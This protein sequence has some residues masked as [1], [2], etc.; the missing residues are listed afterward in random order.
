MK[1]KI[2]FVHHSSAIG[3]ASW[4]LYE[5]LK[6]LDRSRFDPVVL[7]SSE[8]PL[9]GRIRSLDIPVE[10]D[11][12]TPVFPIYARGQIRGLAYLLKAILVYPEQFKRFYSHCRQIAPDV[13]YL[14]S[15]AQLFLPWPAK[16][17]GVKR[18]IFHN[19]EHWDPQGIL[20]IKL[21]IRS[22]MIKRFVDE[23]FSITECGARGIGFPEK[24]VVV[25]DWPSFDDETDFDVRKKLGI[26]SDKFLILLTGGLMPIK[27]TRDMLQALETMQ[28]SDQVA[29]I[30]L[31]CSPEG[32]SRLKNT[33]RRLFH[34]ISYA[35]QITRLAAGLSGKVFLLPPTLQVKPYMQQCSVLV[36]PFTMPHAAKA[37]LEAQSLERPVIIYD[38]PEAREYIRNGET[39]VIVP[40]GNIR[41]LASALDDLI[42]HPE[43]TARL[44]IAGREFVRDQFDVV[45]SMKQ[46]SEAFEKVTATGL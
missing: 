26:A 36:A 23:V 22:R 31:G 6:H 20:K 37:A 28:M 24:S 21:L 35:D 45:K 42:L 3:G 10:I 8:G 1:K 13:V 39:G 4:C 27:G 11:G 30:V 33:V 41:A 5:I 19:R 46:I 14:N 43:K 32:A 7:L 44:G 34:Q 15:S 29:V 2:L 17:A 16:K 9:A 25:R 38:N 40:S 18:V 12:G